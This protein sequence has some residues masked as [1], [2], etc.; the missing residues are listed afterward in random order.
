MDRGRAPGARVR[1]AHR[2]AFDIIE[3][4]GRPPTVTVALTVGGTVILGR[5]S[6]RRR[7]AS[8]TLRDIARAGGARWA[9]A[10]R[11]ARASGRADIGI[12]HRPLSREYRH[13]GALLTS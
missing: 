7:S 12:W 11:S 8:V 10:P 3:T 2:T 4:L 1:S 6:F 5:L 13:I 9:H